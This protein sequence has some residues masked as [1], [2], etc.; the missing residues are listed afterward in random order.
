MAIFGNHVLGAL[1]VAIGG[2]DCLG[3]SVMR[4]RAQRRCSVKRLFAFH[5]PTTL[6]EWLSLR[7]LQLRP[8]SAVACRAP[9]MLI[10]DQLKFALSGEFHRRLKRIGTVRSTRSPG[11]SRGGAG[12]G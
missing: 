9:P 7:R 1:Q 12:K 4:A 10:S 3:H 5:K 2:E 6:V 8:Y 11:N